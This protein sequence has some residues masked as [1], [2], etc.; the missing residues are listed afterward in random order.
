MP[1]LGSFCL[2]FALALA[3]YCFVVGVI[4]AVR[5]DAVGYRLAETARRAGW[6]PLPPFWWPPERWFMPPSQTTF[7]SL[8]SFIIPIERCRGHINLP[9]YGRGRKVRPLLGAAAFSLWICAAAAPQSRSAAGGHGLNGAGRDPGLLSLFLRILPPTLWHDG[10]R[11][12]RRHRI[13]SAC[14][15][16]QKW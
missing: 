2:L 16:I 1:L 8:T 10:D 9:F 14:C 15:N 6:H 5:Q 7:P 4:A 11:S 13:E 12:R 3:A